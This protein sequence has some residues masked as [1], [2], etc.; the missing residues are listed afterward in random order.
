MSA[1]LVQSAAAF[2]GAA[3]IGFSLSL[4]GAPAAAGNR[5]SYTEVYKFKKPTDGVSGHAGGYYCDYQKLPNM[6]CK[7]DRRGQEKCVRDGWLL[8]K[9]CY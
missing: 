7:V 9:F 6:V 5:D 2:I 1:T 3:A 8:V 4:L